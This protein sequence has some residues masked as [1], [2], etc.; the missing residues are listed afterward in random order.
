MIEVVTTGLYTS[1]QDKGR[2]GYRDQG[3]PNSGAMDQNAARRANYLVKNASTAAVMEC[4][5]VGP[6]MQFHEAVYLA[7]S[8]GI[9][10]ITHNDKSISMNQRFYVNKGDVVTIGRALKGMRCYVA[11]SGG[12]NTPLLLAS[13]SY[14]MGVTAC[15][16]VQKGELFVVGESFNTDVT[17]HPL[18]AID[19]NTSILKVYPGPEFDTLS[20]KIQKEIFKKNF[21]LSSQSNRMACLFDETLSKGAAEIRTAP[22]HTGTVQLT[23]SGAMAIL[24]RD[25]QVTGGY[26]RILQLSDLAIH[27]LAQKRGGDTIQFELEH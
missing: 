9:F 23:P 14:Y 24:L 21:T 10:E 3:V 11:V 8:G 20:K 17:N 22:V 4:T 7:V 5:M 2:F 27:V 15:S 1:I 26:A 6:S 13:R 19:F 16:T 18:P 25:A 12:F